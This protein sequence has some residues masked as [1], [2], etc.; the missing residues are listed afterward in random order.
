MA[1]RALSDLVETGKRKRQNS[2]S[3][4]NAEVDRKRMYTSRTPQHQLAR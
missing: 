4:D 2:C 1:P 3:R